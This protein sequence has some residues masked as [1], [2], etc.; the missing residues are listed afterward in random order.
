MVVIGEDELVRCIQKTIAVIFAHAHE[1]LF[2]AKQPLKTNSDTY[3][4][5]SGD[6]FISNTKWPFGQWLWVGKTTPSLSVRVE[7]KRLLDKCTNLC[8]DG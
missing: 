8:S 1:E 6:A 7:T 4:L 3:L 5:S 2:T